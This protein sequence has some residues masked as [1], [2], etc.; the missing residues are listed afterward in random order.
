MQKAIFEGLVF[1]ERGRTA[2]VAYVGLE[3]HYVV[4]DEGMKFHVPS[5]QV[6][7]QVLAVFQSLMAGHEDFISRETARLLGQEDPFTQAAIATQLKQM[8]QHFDE[9]L[10][11]GLPDDAR[12][13]LGM[14][15]FRVT[16]N[17][18]GEVLDVHI[19]GAEDDPD[20]GWPPEP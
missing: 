3:P 14:M 20:A 12:L 17:F 15:G 16:I 9:M 11:A 13:W 10:K 19:P 8:D 1:D 18:R 6:D 7:R 5:A 2:S 4:E